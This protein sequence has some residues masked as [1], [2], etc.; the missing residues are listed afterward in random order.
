VDQPVGQEDDYGWGIGFALRRGVER[1]A[2]LPDVAQGDYEELASHNRAMEQWKLSDEDAAKLEEIR[3]SEGFW[4]KAGQ[5]MMEPR[6]VLQTVAESL[7]M[8]AAPI[9]GAVGGGLVG[10]AA[11][12]PAAPV[13]AIAGSIT[14]G[15]LGSYFTEYYASIGEFFG[16]QGIDMKNAAELKAA[17]NNTQLMQGARD[18]AFAR[19]VPIAIFD[20][21]SMGLA[22]RIAK[23]ISNLT[24]AVTGGRR[25]GAGMASELV[26]QAGFG[27]AGEAGAQ[28]SSTGEIHDELDVLM[29]GFAELAPGV[30]EAGVSNYV[31]RK[32]EARAAG[33]QDPNT[34]PLAALD[35]PEEQSPITASDID[36]QTGQTVTR[37]GDPAQDELDVALEDGLA[38]L[39]MEL[40]A[41]A[42][43]IDVAEGG[44]LAEAA[45]AE[46]PTGQSAAMEEER[47]ETLAKE[48]DREEARKRQQIKDMYDQRLADQIEADAAAADPRQPS[49]MVTPRGIEVGEEP[50]D[51]IGGQ[52]A[53]G[54]RVGEDLIYEAG[55][56][57]S[58]TALADALRGAGIV[59]PDDTGPPGPPGP[60]TAP[61]GQGP[62]PD[63]RDTA[64][65]EALEAQEQD[66]MF[67]EEDAA[68]RAAIQA[69]DAIPMGPPEREIPGFEPE[70]PKPAQEWA[71]ERLADEGYHGGLDRLVS[72]TSER[73]GVTLIPDM[74][75]PGI[76]SPEEATSFVG[77]TPSTNPPWMQSIVA[78]EGVGRKYVI[79]AVEKAKAGKRLGVKQQRIIQGMLDEIDAPTEY[80]GVAAPEPYEDTSPEIE[81]ARHETDVQPEGSIIAEARKAAAPPDFELTQEQD[82]VVPPEPVAPA[83]PRQHVDADIGV[84][85][86]MF[87][88]GAN[89]QVDLVDE[90]R[91]AAKEAR[92]I[93]PNLKLRDMK[94]SE[95]TE[96]AEETEMLMTQFEKEGDKSGYDRTNILLSIQKLKLH[97]DPRGDQLME[98]FED[99]QPGRKEAAVGMDADEKSLQE[100]YFRAEETHEKWRKA[101]EKRDPDPAEVAE[102]EQ[103]ID[104]MAAAGDEDAFQLALDQ[105]WWTHW[106]ETEYTKNTQGPGKNPIPIVVKSNHE[107][108]KKSRKSN[109]WGDVSSLDK[110]SSQG[111]SV[112]I[113]QLSW[114][115][116][117]DTLTFESP[118]AQARLDRIIDVYNKTHDRPVKGTPSQMEVTVDEAG[119]M[120]TSAANFMGFNDVL[121]RASKG[122]EFQAAGSP[123]HTIEIET[124]TD[125]TI[126]VN[127]YRHEGV[128]TILVES[129]EI[130]AYDQLA[131][132]FMEAS[133]AA[134]EAKITPQELPRVGPPISMLTADGKFVSIKENTFPPPQNRRVLDEA[135]KDKMKQDSDLSA[136]SMRKK[137]S[138]LT[139][140]GTLDAKASL[141]EWKAEAKRIGDTGVNKNKVIISLFDAT[142]TW[143]QPYLDAGYTVL[144]YDSAR[145]DDIHSKDWYQEIEAIKEKGY[146]IAGVMAAPPCTSF[147][148]AGAQWWGAQHDRPS[149]DWVQKKYGDLA[150]FHYD[151]PIDY[152]EAIM[153]DVVA[154]V[155]LAQPTE[156]HAME[157]PSGR[158]RKMLKEGDWNTDIGLPSISFDPWHFGDP[159]TKRTHLWGEMNTDLPIATV[160][161]TEGSKMHKMSSGAE[162]IGGERS[163]TPEGFSY[164]FFMANH[165]T[166]GTE[167]ETAPAPTDAPI[168]SEIAIAAAANVA[169]PDAA[170]DAQ[171]DAGNY[172]KGH[173]TLAGLDITIE[174]PVGTVRHGNLKLKDH[175]GY[176]KRTVGA[177]G[178][179][180]DVFVNAKAQ[181]DWAGDIYIVDQTFGDVGG[182][183]EHKVMFGYNNLIDARRAYKRNFNKDWK[184]EGAVTK[185]T[186]DEFNAWLAEPGANK[187]PAS[188]SNVTE[189]GRKERA[190]HHKDLRYASGKDIFNAPSEAWVDKVLNP[191]A[192][193]KYAEGVFP[194]HGDMPDTVPMNM[195][196]SQLLAIEA[197]RTRTTDPEA[198]FGTWFAGSKVVNDDGAPLV[199][200][201]GTDQGFDT[202]DPEARG[203]MTGAPSAKEAFFFTNRMKTAEWYSRGQ[204]P[205]MESAWRRAKHEGTPGPSVKSVYLS[206]QNPLVHDFKGKVYRETKYSELVEQAKA[207]GNDGVIM[208]NTF[209]AGE[210]TKMDA[211]LQGK[212]KG[213][214]IYAVFDAAQIKS[215]DEVQ[216]DSAPAAPAPSF[217]AI[218]AA[219]KPVEESL[220]G[221]PVTLLHNYKQA[222]RPVALAMQDQ[223]MTQVKAVFDPQTGEI[224]MFSDQIGSIDEAIR[225]SFHE[226]T[227]RGLRVAFGERLNPLLDDIYKNATDERQVNMNTIA[228]RYKIDRNT[229]EGQRVV[230]EE[231]LAHM[232]EH[233]VTDGIV[234]RAVAFIRKLLRDMGVTINFSDNDIRA[235]IREAQGSISRSRPTNLADVTIEE[236]VTVEGSEEIYVVEQ[237]ADVALTGINNRIEICRKLRACV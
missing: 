78:N 2:S 105:D 181:E 45:R 145:G 57:P 157:N 196:V 223:G 191:T 113:S 76:T 85:G 179:Q 206:M 1:L 81:K 152:A 80:E 168:P 108:F 18:H 29:E 67:A 21:L 230:A 86:D 52:P 169:Q 188:H 37:T 177:D 228:E 47:A 134:S 211:I 198:N 192:K 77:R 136:W 138:K 232:A 65:A 30:V 162:V 11:A 190:K 125:G 116:P 147:A 236:E 205:N 121:T 122:E 142:G 87:S 184:G 53:E 97:G 62:A 59:P 210:Y 183:D 50:I 95:L 131:D 112:D 174:N 25:V 46:S 172:K 36:P 202:F 44:A 224:F 82:G 146:T 4:N 55:G 3:N 143:S 20:G 14:G 219:I 208:L 225:T 171:K 35:Q 197:E 218:A 38:G 118:E 144:R 141:D 89:A 32:A 160:A 90:S 17:F 71:D 124:A 217:E 129:G 216:R 180:V 49:E 31:D 226:K 229:R 102:I 39:Q 150:A 12:G 209:D 139:F 155:D 60:P 42:M 200:F 69:D 234:N 93:P 109:K 159:Y 64:A 133:V 119:G 26:M 175:Y 61:T 163:A 23:P 222:P 74:D 173:M 126:E 201:H 186:L 107:R 10:G 110:V 100:R 91:K 104:D 28:I 19:G 96:L 153:T 176:I 182:F 66:R 212:F 40:E 149:R 117:Y 231:L 7:P 167:V 68:E 101:I 114:T 199:V 189:A 193:G 220:P 165:G 195:A 54:M 83:Q 24:K 120:R 63:A 8:M 128:Q 70:G 203:K 33:V 166:P 88:P 127:L 5:L 221:A 16:E 15:A 187:L 84:P 106:G 140:G 213:D 161:P 27:M 94:P 123:S 43:G 135:S 41:E 79:N 164:A 72:E 103:L 92:G 237:N 148:S 56:R 48:N 137:G 132:K 158:L 115:V 9:T 215:V 73:G 98:V 235:L 214:T 13:G 34:S 178:D 111:V 204:A 170:S 154:I 99:R 51:V 207:A 151:K 6:L 22:G 227:H 194:V 156:F 233:D 58:G 130:A 185:M 75:A